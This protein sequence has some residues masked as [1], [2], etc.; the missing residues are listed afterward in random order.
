MSEK[1]RWQLWKESQAQ[2]K[3][4]DLFNPE[5]HVASEIQKKRYEICLSCPELIQSTKTCKICGCF[6]SQKTKLKNASCPIQKW[7]KVN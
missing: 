5:N 7:D 4:W 2:A 3:P 1:S 6:M